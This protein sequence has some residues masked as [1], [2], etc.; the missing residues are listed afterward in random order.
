MI[1]QPDRINA[2]F[3]FL[4]LFFCR[5]RHIQRKLFKYLRKL[6]CSVFCVPASHGLSDLVQGRLQICFSSGI[7][8]FICMI[9]HPGKQNSVTKGRGMSMRCVKKTGHLITHC[10]SCSSLCYIYC[11]PCSICRH[12]HISIS[13][14]IICQISIHVIHDHFNCSSAVLFAFFRT[15]NRPER[16]DRMTKSIHHSCLFLINR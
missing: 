12:Q 4:K 6:C 2:C 8:T 7:N 1:F 10:V 5:R 3:Q 16:F 11:L 13:L 9:D 14:V 15:V